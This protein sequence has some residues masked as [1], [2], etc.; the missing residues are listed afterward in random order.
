MM[1]ARTG[2]STK[3]NENTENNDNN[4]K[5]VM[6]MTQKWRL[7]ERNDQRKNGNN[8]ELYSNTSS[9]IQVESNEV[10]DV[11]SDA[12]GDGETTECRIEIVQS[13]MD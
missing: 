3:D 7:K 10:R 5:F 2:T 1:M 9:I 4:S 12:D 8:S 6:N 11:K 13:P